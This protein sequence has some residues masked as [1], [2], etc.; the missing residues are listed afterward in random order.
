MENVIKIVKIFWPKSGPHIKH[1]DKLYIYSLCHSG[2]N[3]LVHKSWYSTQRGF[4]PYYTRTVPARIVHS[5]VQK[6]QFSSIKFALI[7]TQE[8]T[9]LVG[10]LLL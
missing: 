3:Q 5:Y 8:W 2:P 9:I 10:V 4:F 7:C 6:I 1:S